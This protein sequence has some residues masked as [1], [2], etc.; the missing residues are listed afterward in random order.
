M[1]AFS[2]ISGFIGGGLGYLLPFVLVLGVVVFVHE[3][4]HF[5]VGRLFGTRIEAFSIGFGRAIAKWKDR[6]GTEWKVGWLPLG[7]YVKFW[8]DEDATSL[9]NKERLERIAA[10]PDAATSFHFKPLWQRALIVAAGPFTNFLFAVIVFAG[11]YM[12]SGI[13]SF[14]PVVGSV[15]EGSAAQRAGLQPGDRI[16]KVDG[17]TISDFA[18][19]QRLML[20]NGG[21]PVALET[22]RR[23]EPQQVVVTPTRIESTDRFG[24]KYSVFQLGIGS[25]GLDSATWKRLGPI[26]A[27]NQSVSQVYFFVEHTFTFL[28]RLIMGREDPKMLSGPLGIAKTS[29]EVAKL[30]TVALIQLMAILSVSVGLLN[31]FPIPMLDGGHLLYYGIEAVRRRPLGERAQEYGLRIGLA[32]VLSLMLFA[33]WNDV[34]RIFWS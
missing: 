2:T 13:A 4:G 25:P 21:S 9:P 27:L 14:P 31:L 6:H 23:G 18:E 29:G 32:L 22:E 12:A 34:M 26:E 19:I 7:G 16:L 24:N 30:G 3:S 10:D 28:G 5:W 8:G 20:L 15:I 11:L 33:T 1:D 17:E